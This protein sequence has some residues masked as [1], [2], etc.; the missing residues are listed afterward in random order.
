MTPPP[1]INASSLQAYSLPELNRLLVHL[2]ETK[3]VLLLL[4][5]MNENP[6]KGVKSTSN[7]WLYLGSCVG[8]GEGE[9][10]WG[11]PASGDG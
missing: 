3:G 1:L 7:S 6:R 10:W 2:V 9:G 5:L 11:E 4:R 8:E